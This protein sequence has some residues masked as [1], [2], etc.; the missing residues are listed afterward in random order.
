[1]FS[2]QIKISAQPLVIPNIFQSTGF[3]RPNLS[4]DIR[5]ITFF[6]GDPNTVKMLKNV[7]NKLMQRDEQM[8]KMRK[9]LI[10]RW[11]TLD[12]FIKW[13]KKES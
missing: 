13:K 6:G 1:M 3:K 2:K 11:Q 10:Q 12:Y 8:R 5:S 4:P 9:S 7:I